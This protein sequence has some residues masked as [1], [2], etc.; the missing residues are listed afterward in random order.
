M[1]KVSLKGIPSYSVINLTGV[2]DMGKSPMVEQFTVFRASKGDKVAFITVETPANFV[3]A[4]LKLR[5]VA[6]GL[7]FEQF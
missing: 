4:S 7:D 5:A 2:S 1:E 3:S 6:M